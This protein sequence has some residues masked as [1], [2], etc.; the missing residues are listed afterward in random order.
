M[1]HAGAGAPLM[2][3]PRCIR[4]PFADHSRAIR[5]ACASGRRA[6]HGPFR[7]LARRLCRLTF[8]AVTIPARFS[9]GRLS[10]PPAA[11]AIVL[12]SRIMRGRLQLGVT[13]ACGPGAAVRF[14]RRAG[15]AIS[16]QRH[17][18]GPDAASLG[19]RHAHEQFSRSS[20]RG[21]PGSSS[22]DSA[23]GPCARRGWSRWQRR[24]EVLASFAG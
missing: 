2:H 9:P 5:G 4:V 6:L 7:A 19:V 24:D 22:C 17:V 11:H 23:P 12:A 14:L 16:T 3:H 1:R 20:G 18:R 8:A 15:R 13:S 10:P 21:R